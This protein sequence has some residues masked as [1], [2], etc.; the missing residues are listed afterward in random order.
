MKIL[1]FT[2][3]R[4][5][6][7]S[8]TTTLK[9]EIGSFSIIWSNIHAGDGSTMDSYDY[10]VQVESENESLAEIVS[11]ALREGES[12]DNEYIDLYLAIRDECHA[13]SFND[14]CV[15]ENTKIADWDE[16]ESLEEA[17]ITVE[18]STGDTVSVQHTGGEHKPS[19]GC[20]IFFNDEEASQDTEQEEYMCQ[21]AI[22]A[23]EKYYEDRLENE[24][25]DHSLPFN[26]SMNND[27]YYLRVAKESG[28]SVIIS[29]GQYHN[30]LQSRIKNLKTFDNEKD[31]WEFINSFKT[32]DHHDFTGLNAMLNNIQLEL[33]GN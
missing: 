22:E 11:E 6:E 31:A 33:S 7:N 21:A 32:D 27:S 23:A 5:S 1:D 2:A 9:T 20:L 18:F 12:D 26:C 19:L 15:V 16:S 14:F 29:R 13:I 28:E 4:T 17:T 10:D 24:L 30:D 3:Q 8:V 25:E